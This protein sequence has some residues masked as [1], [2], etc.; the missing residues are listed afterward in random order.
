MP[1]S[2]EEYVLIYLGSCEQE[3][4][5]IVD[6]IGRV[7]LIVVLQLSRGHFT[8]AMRHSELPSFSSKLLEENIKSSLL[9][10]ACN[11]ISK[12]LPLRQKCCIPC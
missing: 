3:P 8:E 7:G 11:L 5:Y 6:V 12:A 10:A 4:T 9:S 1:Q 2:W